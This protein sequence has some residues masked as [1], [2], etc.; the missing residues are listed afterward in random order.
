MKLEII[1]PFGPSIVKFKLPDELVLEM[2]KYADQI[3]NDKKKSE[4]LN[5]GPKLAGNVQQEFLLDTDFMKKIK[6]AEILANI[7]AEWIKNKRGRNLKNFRI[8]KS[9]IVRQ[10]KNEYNPLHFHSG[11]ISGVGYLKVP[12]NLGSTVQEGKKN[13]MNGKLELV[14]SS[15]KFL[16][17]GNYTATPQ[18]GDMYLFPNYLLHTVYPFSDTEDE[19]RS[20]SFNAEI[21]ELAAAL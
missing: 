21:D 2:N 18:V 8:I 6:W 4:D 5:E 7:T 20:V 10:F 13:N 19:R 14:E 15:P 12:K 1:K 9:W 17:S 11:H 16:C 3:I